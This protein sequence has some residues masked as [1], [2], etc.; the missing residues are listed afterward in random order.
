MTTPKHILVVEDEKH[1][2]IGIKYNLE[3]D[4]FRPEYL[5]EQDI[6]RNP[7]ILRAYDVVVLAGHHEYISRVQYDALQDHHDRGGHLAFFSANDISWQVRYEDDCQTLVC[8]RFE[9]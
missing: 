7:S 5:T 9:G 6:H 1:L 4:G 2:A 8:Y 3:A